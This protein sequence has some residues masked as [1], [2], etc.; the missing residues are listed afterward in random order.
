MIFFFLVY[1]FNYIYI[2]Y[3]VFIW[4]KFLYLCI[5]I[6]FDMVKDILFNYY[7]IFYGDL[8][9]IWIIILIGI[10]MVD[11]L[12]IIGDKNLLKFLC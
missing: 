11:I 9:L 7:N 4:K 8:M 10:N 12:Y 5:Y 6:I 3:F 2:Y 1:Y